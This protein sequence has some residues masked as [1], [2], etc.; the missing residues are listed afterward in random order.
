LIRIK[1]VFSFNPDSC[2]SSGHPNEPGLGRVYAPQGAQG[3][4]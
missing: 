3:I 2:V 4:I 1:R